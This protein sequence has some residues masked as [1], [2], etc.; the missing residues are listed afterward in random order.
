MRIQ[1]KTVSGIVI[2][3]I[4]FIHNIDYQTDV[5]INAVCMCVERRVRPQRSN[6]LFILQRQPQITHTYMYISYHCIIP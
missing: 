2:I 1:F 5:S 6:L 3:L 4:A